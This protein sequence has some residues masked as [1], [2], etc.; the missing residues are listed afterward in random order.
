[1]IYD[2]AKAVTTFKAQI[3]NKT[4]MHSACTYVLYL[5]TDVLE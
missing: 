4:L 2:L 3:Y 1:M 5:H